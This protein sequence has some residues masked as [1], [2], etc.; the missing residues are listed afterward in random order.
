MSFE[1]WLMSFNWRYDG[2][3]E[4]IHTETKVLRSRAFLYGLYLSDEELWDED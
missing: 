4:Y 3:D 1:D 2:D